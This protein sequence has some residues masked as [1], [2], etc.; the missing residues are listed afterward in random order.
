MALRRG[1]WPEDGARGAQALEALALTKC[2]TGF[3]K[4]TDV[5]FRL[6]SAL[7]IVSG[8]Y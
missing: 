4:L 5:S 7:L 6:G 2:S 8:Y 3:P 1:L